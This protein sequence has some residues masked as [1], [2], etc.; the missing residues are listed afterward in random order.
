MTFMIYLLHHFRKMSLKIYFAG[1]VM[2]GRED[3]P[4]YAKI[5]H[6]LKSYGTVLTEIVGSDA[7]CAAGK[8]PF[9]SHDF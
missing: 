7:D 6:H 4:L 2:G 3:G 9:K 1:S 5:V 8:E